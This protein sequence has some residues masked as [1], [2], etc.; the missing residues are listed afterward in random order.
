MYP[1]DQIS[2]LRSVYGDQVQEC[3]DGLDR[4]IFMPGVHMPQGC[5]PE[6]SHALF[7]LNAFALSY[8]GY[9]SHLFLKDRISR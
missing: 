2:S 5:T 8:R 3:S 1:S 4:Y 7:C 6:R 9:T